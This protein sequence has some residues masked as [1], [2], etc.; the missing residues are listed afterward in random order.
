MKFDV[1]AGQEI[2]D[3]KGWDGTTCVRTE[4][5]KAQ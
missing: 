4:S 5:I 2:T 3:S 1:E